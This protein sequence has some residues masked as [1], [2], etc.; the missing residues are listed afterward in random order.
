MSIRFLAGAL[1]TL[2]LSCAQA[3]SFS[4]GLWGDMPY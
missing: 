4:F 2:S 1:L 3:Q